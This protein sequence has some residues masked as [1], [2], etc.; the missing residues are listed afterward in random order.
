M[1]LPCPLRN[2]YLRYFD[3]SRFAASSSTSEASDNGGGIG[4]LFSEYNGSAYAVDVFE[5]SPAQMADVQTNDVVV[6]IDG[7][8][9]HAWSASEV[10]QANQARPGVAGGHHLETRVFA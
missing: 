10:T 6:S 4:V 1:R 7:D 9:S 2:P 3:A 8:R 5:G